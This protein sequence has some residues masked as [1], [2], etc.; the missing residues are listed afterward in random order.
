[1]TLNKSPGNTIFERGLGRKVLPLLYATLLPPYR[2]NL[3][4]LTYVNRYSLLSPG[5][6]TVVKE[7]KDFLFK[8]SLLE[9]AVA[10]ILA[11]A[12]GKVIGAFTDDI[13][14]GIIAKIVGK[15][16]FDSLVAG[17]IRYGTF[18]TALLN[19]IIVG[20]VLFLIVKAANRRKA[21]EAAAGPSS[22]DSLLMEIRDGLKR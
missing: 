13:I 10:V 3:T 6:L 16:N 12:F 17:G 20:T 8:G 5:G 14:G 1:M 21:A 19:F 7:L 22:T 9:L 11:G 18:I 4:P 15:P 2:R